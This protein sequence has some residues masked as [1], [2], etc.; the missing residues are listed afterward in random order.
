MLVST[1][2]VTPPDLRPEEQRTKPVIFTKDNI[3]SNFADA[4]AQISDK[5]LKTESPPFR[6]DGIEPLESKPKS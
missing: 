2:I 5:G 1:G 4:A 3:N 6:D